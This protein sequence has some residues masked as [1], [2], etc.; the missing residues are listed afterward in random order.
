[1]CLLNHVPHKLAGLAQQSKITLHTEPQLFQTWEQR[2]F[3]EEAL[4][5][6]YT[7]SAHSAFLEK[8]SS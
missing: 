7:G 5:S 8:G 2:G 1:M 6:A 3:V 4:K